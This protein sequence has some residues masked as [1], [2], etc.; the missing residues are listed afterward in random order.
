MS[1]L[2]SGGAADA[3]A[4]VAYLPDPLAGF[5]DRVRHELAP[6]CRLRAHITI[7][8]PRQLACEGAAASREL[9]AA[10]SQARALRIDLREVQVFPGSDVVYLSIGAG[11]EELQGLHRS[12][13][14]GR[15]LATELWSYEPHVT[16]A[17]DLPPAEV[18]RARK[19]AEE[20]WRAYAGPREFLLDHVVFV[21]GSPERGWM[22]LKSWELPSPVLA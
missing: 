20:R 3:F 11:R 10:L 15:C 12:L 2:C 7:L 14:Q 21:Q 5:V 1:G 13:N 22:D 19:L 9:E 6:G 18:A 4:L 17:Q 16:L 8:P